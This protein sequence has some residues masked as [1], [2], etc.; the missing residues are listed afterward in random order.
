[1]NFDT[2]LKMTTHPRVCK[3]WSHV[4]RTRDACSHSS[5]SCAVRCS[6]ASVC[7]HVLKCL[8][9]FVC[10]CHFV[11]CGNGGIGAAVG[12]IGHHAR[13]PISFPPLG[14]GKTKRTKHTTKIEFR[15]ASSGFALLVVIPNFPAATTS[16][17]WHL[18]H[19]LDIKEGTGHFDRGMTSLISKH[20]C[21]GGWVIIG[22]RNREG[23]REPTWLQSRVILYITSSVIPPLSSFSRRLCI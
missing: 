6:C 23:A 17:V 14:E 22:S 19:G 15:K 1:M 9:V 16:C 18:G 2:R 11:F 5:L 7:T 13:R 10:K 20:F 4:M 3:Q 21:G 12:Q 8:I